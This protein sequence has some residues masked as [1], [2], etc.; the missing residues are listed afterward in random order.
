MSGLCLVF[1][2][3]LYSL[4]PQII[5]QYTL[6]SPLHIVLNEKLT[7]LCDVRPCV[8]LTHFYYY[9]HFDTQNNLP[10]PTIESYGVPQP[11]IQLMTE[12]VYL[13]KVPSVLEPG[14]LGPS[15]SKL[16]P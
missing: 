10:A 15:F 13:N 1:S 16:G 5:L 2:F 12:G 7:S 8:I 9:F 4:L 11:D 14:W 3:D 6:V